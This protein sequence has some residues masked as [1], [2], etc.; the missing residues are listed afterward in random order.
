MLQTLTVDGD[1]V[2]TL[3]EHDYL[4]AAGMQS[5]ASWCVVVK[6]ARLVC[7][8]FYGCCN[9]CAQLCCCNAV[10]IVRLATKIDL[11]QLIGTCNCQ[12]SNLD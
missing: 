3:A 8:R 2:V 10:Q 11:W 1:G 6:R 5:D 7:L 12:S 4:T 9:L